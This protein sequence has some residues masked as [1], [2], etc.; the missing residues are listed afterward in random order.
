MKRLNGCSVAVVLLTVVGCKG[1]GSGGPATTSDFCMQYAEAICQ[2]TTPCGAVLTTCVS[3][4]EAQCM[5]SAT[6]E[7]TG[8]RTYT[9]GN[10][11]AC[12]NAV[13]A[14]Y[15][16]AHPDI[17]VQTMA[18]IKLACGYVFQGSVKLLATGCTTQFDC[19]GATN[20]TIIC[21]N[22]YCAMQT[23]PTA[24]D[25]PCGNPGQVCVANYY[26]AANASGVKV[27]T[28]DAV[29]GAACSDSV[30]CAQNLRCAN[31]TCG[32]LLPS[33]M[34]CAADS[35]C[36]ASAPYCAP[37]VSPPICTASLNFS[38][39]SPSCNCIT[40]GNCGGGAGT[41]GAGGSSGAAGTNGAGGSNGAGGISGAGGL[42][43]SL[44]AGGLGGLGA[45]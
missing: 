33:G 22:T 1:G 42:G 3:Y 43:G 35:D 2:V 11:A 32:A 12:I 8:T 4:Q 27:C 18:N 6:A 7:T 9:P 29:S 25:Q 38:T 41:G 36:A 44:G 45:V 19:A 40:A 28:A 14:A 17:S 10:A 20:G 5:A 15:G 21:D 26:C 31:G 37:Y 13:S 24:A 39:G 34:P 23:S 16:G 30:P